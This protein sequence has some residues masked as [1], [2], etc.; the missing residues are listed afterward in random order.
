[1]T[2]IFYDD[3]FA[4][5]RA[6]VGQGFDQHVCFLDEFIHAWLPL[7]EIARLASMP[8]AAAQSRSCLIV[9]YNTTAGR[10]T[11]SRMCLVV[12]GEELIR[13]QVRILLCGA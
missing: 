10:T 6:N 2:T 1:M 9:F 7:R 8:A 11:G 3:G 12:Y 4:L 13:R 5:E